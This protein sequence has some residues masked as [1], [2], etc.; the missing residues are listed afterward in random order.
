MKRIYGVPGKNEAERFHVHVCV[1]LVYLYTH[2][3]E[4]VCLNVWTHIGVCGH[5]YMSVHAYGGYRLT[6]GVSLNLAPPYMLKLGFSLE[7]RIAR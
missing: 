2:I 5:I 3:H 1:R 6:V 4:Y 7:F